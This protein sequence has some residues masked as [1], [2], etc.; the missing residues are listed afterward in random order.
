MKA[1]TISVYQRAQFWRLSRIAAAWFAVNGVGIL[2]HIPSPWRSLASGISVAL[3]EVV[4]RHVAP[5]GPE[6][7]AN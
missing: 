4:Y 2:S 1:P 5:A 7:K 3:I 6:P